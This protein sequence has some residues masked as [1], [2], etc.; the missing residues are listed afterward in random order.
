MRIHQWGLIN[1]DYQR[2]LLTTSVGV[3]LWYQVSFEFSVH[4]SYKASLSRFNTDRKNVP[5]ISLLNISPAPLDLYLSY[6]SDLRRAF[7]WQ[8]VHFIQFILSSLCGCGAVLLAAYCYIK[9]SCHKHSVH[10]LNT[11]LCFLSCQ[12]HRIQDSQGR[13]PCRTLL[14]KVSLIVAW[15][16]DESAQRACSGKCSS[17]TSHWDKYLFNILHIGPHRCLS[18]IR[19]DQYNATEPRHHCCTFHWWNWDHD[20]VTARRLFSVQII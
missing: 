16:P 20:S 9:R 17:F 12:N 3:C 5:H 7:G 11:F 8:A 4:P 10:N 6:V 13:K 15:K 2:E 1:R 19:Q 18:S 14:V